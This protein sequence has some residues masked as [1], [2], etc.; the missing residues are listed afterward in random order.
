M[1]PSSDCAPESLAFSMKDDDEATR[2]NV[3]SPQ[4]LQFALRTPQANRRSM[5]LRDAAAVCSGLRAAI[6]ARCAALLGVQERGLRD[7]RRCVKTP[8]AMPRSTSG[9]F[10][11]SAVM[12]YVPLAD[13]HG[14]ASVAAAWAEGRHVQGKT[15]D[16]TGKHY[17]CCLVCAQYTVT[18]RL[19][20]PIPASTTVH[21][22]RPSTAVRRPRPY[23]HTVRETEKMR[24]ARS[25][26]SGGRGRGEGCWVTV[27]GILLSTDRTISISGPFSSVVCTFMV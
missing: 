11:H 18:G 26:G 6:S 3:R 22:P 4:H 23:V 19:G 8:D 27:G 24:N 21:R 10:G 25:R 5:L 7:S 20:Y 16:E 14:V 2:T 15:F 12:L 9:Q 1:S 17:F 13:L